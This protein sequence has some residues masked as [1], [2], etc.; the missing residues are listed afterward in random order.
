M[1]HYTI[2]IRNK[3]IEAVGTANKIVIP[4]SVTVIFNYP[5]KYV[6]PG[7]IDTHV[8]LATDPSN[9]DNSRGRKGI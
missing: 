4:D 6:M 8:H 9:D 5:G 7:L 2:V 1:D 3:N